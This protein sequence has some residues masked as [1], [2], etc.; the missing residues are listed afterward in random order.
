MKNPLTS[1]K[2]SVEDG[3]LTDPNYSIFDSSYAVRRKHLDS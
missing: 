1:V 3:S 2:L